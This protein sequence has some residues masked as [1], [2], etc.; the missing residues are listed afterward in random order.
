MI[1]VS[2]GL[3]LRTW[4]WFERPVGKIVGHLR[5]DAPPP[6]AP[7]VFTARVHHLR[8]AVSTAAPA[9]AHQLLQP[10]DS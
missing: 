4:H 8:V 7:V 5:L 2:T 1:S 9:A 3:V 6:A 10:D